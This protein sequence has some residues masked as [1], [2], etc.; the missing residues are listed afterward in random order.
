M[1]L[2]IYVRVGDQLVEF[3]SLPEEE[4]ESIGYKS[5]EK[6]ADGIMEPD[7]YCREKK[8]LG[9]RKKCDYDH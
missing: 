8:F 3:D 1:S 7:G 9:K 5:F 4:K 6:L 2:T